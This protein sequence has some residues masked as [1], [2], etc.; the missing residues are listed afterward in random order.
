MQVVTNELIYEVLKQIQTDLAAVKATL[1]DHGRQ[2]IEL[3]KQVNGVQA[4][5]IRLEE[6]IVGVE[7]RLD[8]IETR[9]NL[10]DA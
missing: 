1:A 4:E 5:I 7:T 10:V 6:R 2:F 3:R 8:R 9:L